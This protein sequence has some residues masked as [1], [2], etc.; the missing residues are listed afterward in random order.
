MKNRPEMSSAAPTD[1]DENELILHYY[2][3]SADP[4]AVAKALASEYSSI[5]AILWMSAS[6]F[7][8][9]WRAISKRPSSTSDWKLVPQALSRRLK[10]RR[11][12]EKNAA[13]WS[14]L[15]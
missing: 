10:V 9:I 2:G 3:E 12:S 8:S 7:S 15:A 13:T 1:M 6:V 11:C 4:E 5:T 14:A